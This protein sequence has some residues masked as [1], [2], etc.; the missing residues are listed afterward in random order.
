V[1]D[2]LPC[3]FCGGEAARS[4]RTQSSNVGW[5]DGLGSPGTM[6]HVERIIQCNTCN[7]SVSNFSLAMSTAKDYWKELVSKWNT[8]VQLAAAV[9]PAADAGQ[10]VALKLIADFAE[11]DG[12]SVC[13][14]IALTARNALK[15]NPARRD[16]GSADEDVV[17]DAKRYRW[18]RS[19]H[20]SD[21]D[22][23]VVQHPRNAVK[24]GHDC[25]SGGRLD[26][27]IDAAMRTAA[28]EE[29]K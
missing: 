2:L 22:I 4:E 28:Q 26:E 20:W 25:P 19:R 3:P 24:L 21:H 11:A 8:R 16:A 23:C 12:S 27:L 1:S 6:I 7:V 13:K 29:S 14:S 15:D 5:A 9:E 10:A 18:L 17:R